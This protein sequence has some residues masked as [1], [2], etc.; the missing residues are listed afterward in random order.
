MRT[1]LVDDAVVTAAWDEEDCE[2]ELTAA[3]WD[4]E[5]C[6]TELAAAA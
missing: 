5:D 4:E 2:P 3:A 6:E 1:E